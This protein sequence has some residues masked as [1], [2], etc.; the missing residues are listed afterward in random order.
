VVK[1]AFSANSGPVNWLR[2]CE[3]SMSDVQ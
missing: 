3:T 2:K 1:F